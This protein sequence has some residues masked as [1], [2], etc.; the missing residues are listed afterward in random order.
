[1]QT[2]KA[3]TINDA[4]HQA[5]YLCW[6]HGYDYKIDSG[7]YSGQIRRQFDLFACEITQPET[8]PLAI[9]FPEGLSVPPPN[10]ET[11]IQDYA[12]HYLLSAE[13][14]KNETYT[15][16]SRMLA[17]PNPDGTKTDQL[18]WIIQHFKEYPGNNHCTLNIP[19][20]GDLMLSHAPCLRLVDLKIV[21]GK[22]DITVYFRSWD[23]WSGFP[24]NLGGFQIFNEY[25]AQEV[26][27]PTGKMFAVSAG[28]HLYE[29]YFDV[30]K[31]RFKRD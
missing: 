3:V 26:G 13:V 24:T 27:I 28:L 22:L 9:K 1:M 4:W 6:E 30:V 7:S 12:V 25:V 8:R 17:F 23:L 10:T 19:L 20:G 2:V 29:M 11:Q 15:Y 16:G 18:E 14:S 21:G 5:V 31:A